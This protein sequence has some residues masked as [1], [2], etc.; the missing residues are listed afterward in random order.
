MPEQPKG[1]VAGSVVIAVDRC[2]GCGF[3]VEF[4]PPNALQL[5]DQYNARGYH[6]PVLRQSDTCTG[7][8][9]CGLMCPDFAIFGFVRKS[10]THRRTG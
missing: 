1:K 6:P 3:C 10:R 2:K 8:N 7:C 9:I 4:C 5:S